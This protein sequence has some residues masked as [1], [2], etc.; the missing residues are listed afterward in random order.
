[1]TGFSRAQ[2]TQ[3]IGDYLRTGRVAADVELPAVADK[4]HESLSGSATQHVLK[5]ESKVSAVS[6]PVSVQRSRA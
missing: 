2:T 3:L 4:A 1:M 5:R 6:S